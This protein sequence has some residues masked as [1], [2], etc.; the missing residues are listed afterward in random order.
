ML[1]DL[2][3]PPHPTGLPQDHHRHCLLPHP[4]LS[5]DFYPR[6]I[7]L[8]RLMGLIRAVPFGPGPFLSHLPLLF[9]ICALSASAL[10][11]GTLGT[12]LVKI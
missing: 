3:V 1:M 9:L 2:Y 11:G 6:P 4:T 12:N 7:F 5:W 8:S 10:G